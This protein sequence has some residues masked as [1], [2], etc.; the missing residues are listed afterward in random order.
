MVKLTP[1]SKTK[2]VIE[3]PS[4]L[5]GGVDASHPVAFGDEVK[6][7]FEKVFAVL[8][9]GLLAPTGPVQVVPGVADLLDAKAAVGKMLSTPKNTNLIR[10]K[11]EQVWEEND[12][13]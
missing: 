9:K 3:S 8:E 11:L 5:V 12:N 4:V 7:A 10:K 2:T 13:G 1:P 6:I